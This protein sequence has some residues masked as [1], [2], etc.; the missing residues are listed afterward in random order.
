MSPCGVEVGNGGAGKT[1]L[2]ATIADRR[3]DA[4]KGPYLWLR[5]GNADEE[6]V[7]DGL[8]RCLA[9]ALGSDAAVPSAGDARLLAIGGQIAQPSSA[10]S[11]WISGSR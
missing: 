2:A 11:F 4:G 7:L 8:A 10:S 3:I 9:T 1:A 6:V 5:T